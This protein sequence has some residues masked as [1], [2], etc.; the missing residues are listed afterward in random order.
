MSARLIGLILLLMTGLLPAQALETT[1]LRTRRDLEQYRHIVNTLQATRMSVD[2]KDLPL[3]EAIT[4]L[5]LQTGVNL[6]LDIKALEDRLDREISFRL[7]RVPASLVVQLLADAGEVV[8][9]HRHGILYVTSL[10]DALKRSVVLQIYDVA[11]LLYSPPDFPGPRLGLRGSGSE[12]DFEEEEPEREEKDPE[13]LVDLIKLA[14]GEQ[15]WEPEFVSIRISGR[16]LIVRHTP[17]MQRK[18]GGVMRGL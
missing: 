12:G 10:E 6:V 16:K 3:S 8:F 13:A 7:E 15:A 9:Q 18:I 17:A 1:A 14:T 4:A 2:W 11:D 5:R